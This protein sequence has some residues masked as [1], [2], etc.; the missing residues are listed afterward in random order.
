M[1]IASLV[2]AATYLLLILVGT[3]GAL[4]LIVW[5]FGEPPT[6]ARTRRSHTTRSVQNVNLSGKSKPA[7]PTEI[8]RSEDRAA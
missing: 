1:S 2:V 8:D 3:L 5:L 6:K 7:T 4:F